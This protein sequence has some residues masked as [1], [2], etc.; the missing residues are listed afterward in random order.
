MVHGLCFL[1][2][3]ESS[4]C[5]NRCAK[6]HITQTLKWVLPDTL[7]ASILISFIQPLFVSPKAVKVVMLGAGSLSEHVNLVNAGTAQIHT[8]LD[9]AI[10]LHCTYAVSLYEAEWYRGRMWAAGCQ[11]YFVA[12]CHSARFVSLH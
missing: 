10:L 11:H 4:D 7:L 6:C 8:H 1:S 2:A 9:L 12:I 3:V 5:L